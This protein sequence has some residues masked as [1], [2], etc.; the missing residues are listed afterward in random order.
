MKLGRASILLF[1]LAF[2]AATAPA[3]AAAQEDAPDTVDVERRARLQRQGGGI[4]VGLWH[5]T[6]LTE[7]DGMRE[8]AWPLLEGYFQRGLDLHL[9]VESSVGLWRREI[10]ITTDGALGGEEDE[11]A[12]TYVVPLMTSLKFFPFT[13]PDAALEP[14]VLG[15]IGFAVG[16]EDSEGTSAGL[17]RSDAGTNVLTGFGAKGAVGA[18][19]RFDDAFG[20]LVGVSYQWIRFGAELAGDRTYAGPAFHVGLT[21]RFQY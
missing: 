2:A 13:R 7:L 4:R 11:R 16:I 21:Y 17:L 19:W 5:V 8:S 3:S 18:Q 10:E 9:A 1:A 6:S 20:G 15:G 12:T 14:F